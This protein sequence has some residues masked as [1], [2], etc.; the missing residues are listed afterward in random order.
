MEPL[1]LYGYII[2]FAP[3]VATAL[4]TCFT[5]KHKAVSSWIAIG[6]MLVAFGA[7]VLAA[8]QVFGA[9]ASF[10]PVHEIEWLSVGH[11]MIPFGVQMD[12][13]SVM[14]SLIV[15]GVGL[16]IFVFSTGYMK[17]E[18]GWSRYFAC[19]SLF[20]FSMLGIVLSTN[21]IQ[22]FIFW[23]LVGVS[24]YALI[25]YYF[26]KDSAVDAGKKAF[27]TNRIGDFGMTWGIILLFYTL[28]DTL[29]W[30]RA[31]F[32]YEKLKLL[33]HAS[34]PL[35]VQVMAD[36]SGTLALATLLIFTGA[37]AKS[38]QVPL[39]V[40]LP[41]AMEGPTP[42]S[43]LMHAATMVA[44]GVFLVCR[45]FFMFAPYE[46]A[47]GVV[48]WMGGITALLAAGVAFVQHDIKKVLAY[49]T[50]SQ[51]GYMVLA[52]GMGAPAAAMFHLTTHA[53][54]KALLFLG[55]GSVIYGCHHEQDMRKMGG[56][57]KTMPVTFWTFMIGTAAL[58]GIAPFSGFWSKDAILSA[59]SVGHVP[60]A[61]ILYGM[62]VLVALM[63]AAY[64]GR[65]VI[66]TFFGEYRGHAKPHESP[67]SM[68]GPLVVL[69]TASVFAGVLSIPKGISE[70]GGWLEHALVGATTAPVW[71][72]GMH[73]EVFLPSVA[74][75]GTVAALFGLFLAY[76]FYAKKAWSID[77]FVAA[78]KPLHTLLEKKY[79]F[80]EA[81]LWLVANVQQT[82]AETCGFIEVHV[83]RRI[84]DAVAG[85]TRW[86]GGQVRL[87][88]DGHLHRYVTLALFGAVVIIA[89]VLV[90]N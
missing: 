41:D 11:V 36:H 12:A 18:D 9:D 15:T 78:V 21:L 23:E 57:R 58:A 34:D 33:Y 37:V 5:L 44:A 53:F 48:A 71:F 8:M 20:S 51:L 67:V 16:C 79:Y 74:I 28:V 42:V 84:V 3:L 59:A 2:L 14:M 39:H 88:L 29:G 68:T 30:E 31:S 43:A 47:L 62:G 40:W 87:L 82:I 46:I 61:P 52:L 49:S 90:G 83:L 19:L 76:M 63:T 22:T 64:M 89:A 65:C 38:A 80:D 70:H 86:F 73:E 35:I 4:I 54:F 10:E 69:A 13:L 66:L 85:T 55:S 45:L 72:P 50:L 1:A 26:H 56:L 27:L 17:G 77:S 60:G 7:N 32:S 6:G 25:G 75:V 24:S 81:Y